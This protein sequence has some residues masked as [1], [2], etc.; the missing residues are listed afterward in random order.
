MRSAG[1]STSVKEAFVVALDPVTNS[2]LHLPLAKDKVVG[3]ILET[4]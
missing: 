3:G 1:D 2:I 4:K